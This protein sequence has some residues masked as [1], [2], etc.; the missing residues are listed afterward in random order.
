M[1][2]VRPIITGSWLDF[3]HPNF[4]EGDYW[5]DTTRR[6]T[7]QD[8]D[9][10]VAEMAE[11]G[12]DTLVLL[13]VALRGA[14][15]YPSRHFDRRW[16]L[17]CE[18]PVAALLA[19]AD[20]HG[21]KVFVGVGYFAHSTGDHVG[22]AEDKRLRAVIPEELVERYGHH[23]S[24]HG[25]YLPVE[26]G[27]QGH[28]SEAFM[29][30]AAELCRHC[31]TADPLKPILIAPYGTRTVIPDG[32][33]VEQ[34]RALDVDHVAYQCEV[35]VRKTRVEELDEIFARL[36]AVH[37]KA[38]V[39]LWADVE[40]FTF[41]GET[42]RSPLLPAPF[43]RVRRQ[44]EAMAPHV[45]KLLCYQ[46]LGMMNPPHSPVFAGHPSSARLYREYKEWVDE[47]RRL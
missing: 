6:F 10:K 5:N 24:F 41:E 11:L 7:A 1:P 30:Y 34:L 8:W 37:E 18:D 42:Y 14:S 46:Y 35:G 22:D 4:R 16:D 19:A 36:K 13:S 26:A 21:M 25:W 23:A 27:I 29:D 47:K 38:G 32:R 33:F 20:R 31:R 45:E 44:L 3:H 15:F 43:E 12:M 2:P 17:I 39:P 9:T 28:F 40:V